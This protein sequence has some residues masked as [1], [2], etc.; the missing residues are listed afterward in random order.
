MTD[1]DVVALTAVEKKIGLRRPAFGRRF[2]RM[3]RWLVA[4]SVALSKLALG[5]LRYLGFALTR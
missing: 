4:E 1:V 5:R 2:V 3:D